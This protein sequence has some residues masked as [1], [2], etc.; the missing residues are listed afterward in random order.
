MKKIIILLTFFVSFVNAD[1]VDVPILSI[2]DNLAC[3]YFFS[4]VFFVFLIITPT[5]FAIQI[6]WDY[7]TKVR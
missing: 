7:A 6:I 3:N 5:K 1:M 2:T 4:L